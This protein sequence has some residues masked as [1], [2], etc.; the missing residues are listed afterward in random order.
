MHIALLTIMLSL[1]GQQSET[2]EALVQKALERHAADMGVF[3]TL[4]YDKLSRLDDLKEGKE[5]EK[6]KESVKITLPKLLRSGRY[7]YEFIESDEN[8]A[9]KI[10]FFPANPETQPGPELEQEMG[11]RDRQ[12][13]DGLNR[14]INN[15]EGTLLIDKE[16]LGIIKLE[17]HLPKPLRVKVM[18]FEE[19][20]INYEQIWVFDIWVPKKIEVIFKFDDIKWFA[21]LFIHDT[22][23]RSITV[24]VNYRRP[25]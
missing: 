12:L 16:T 8:P 7:V 5:K 9:I 15:I 1:S 6:H 17:A 22:H 20:S 10:R 19:M 11:I 14:V 4:T 3:K 18:T 21:R 23:E 25:Q 13:E 2:A 24:F